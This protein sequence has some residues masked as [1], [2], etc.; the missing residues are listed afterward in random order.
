MLKIVKFT[1]ENLS[2]G[3]VT[4][5]SNPRFSFS[6][7]SDGQGGRLKRATLKINGET[8]DATEQIGIRYKGAPLKAFTKYTATLEAESD[9]GDRADASLEF[10]TGRMGNPWKAEW[11]TDGGYRFTEKKT[12]PVPMLFRKTFSF[13]KEIRSAKIYATAI[14]IYEL[15][16]NGKKVGRDY[17][18]PGFTSYKSRLQYQTYDVTEQIKKDNTL[19]AT[20]A[21]GWAVGA[22]VMSRKNRIT[23]P[24]QAFLAELRV[25]CADGT[26]AVLGTDE[27]WQVTREGPLR[28]AEFYDGEIFDATVSPE[29][30]S[31]T[32]ASAERLKIRP[33]LEA[34]YGAPVRAREAFRPV[35]VTRA[36]SGE[37][38]YDFGQNFAGVVKIRVKGKKGQKITVRHAEI[39]TS[40]GE[41]HTAYLRSAKC[42]LVYICRD[43]EQEYSPRMTY[44][45][46]RYAGV[47][48][49][50]EENIELSATALYSE[51][52]ETGVFECSDERI[53]RLQKNIVW[54]GKSN[55]V[56][57]PTD[58][59]QRD[60]RMGWTGDIA[61]FAPT[62]CYNFGMERFL[63]KWLKD[64]KSEQTK[65]GGIPNTVP[66][67]GYGFPETM[68][69][70]AVAFWGDACVFVPWAEY[71]AYGDKDILKEMYPVMKK[72]VKACLFWAGLFS[73]G[74]N[75]YIWNDIPAMQFGDWVAP[76]VPKM[77]EWQARCKWTGTAA[78]ARSTRLL[79]EIASILGNAEDAAKYRTISEKV[80]DAYCSI[81]TDGD[82]KL[83]EEF[84][85]AYVLP[86][87]FKMFPDSVRPKA[88]KN[89]VSLIEK[90]DYRIGTG[91]PGTPYILFALSDNGYA[92]VA[93][94]MLENTQC[95]SWLYE[96]EAGATTVWERW[97]GLDKD[98]T[99]PIGD[100]GTGGMISYN[101]YAFGAV[102]DFLYRRVAGIEATEGGYK[103]FRIAPLAGGGLT[104]ASGSVETPYGKITSAWRLADG[105]FH[106]EAEVPFGTECTLKM[107]SGAERVLESGRYAFS[108]SYGGG[109]K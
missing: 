77:L 40:E 24:R 55:F 30:I 23:A 54:S 27:T 74:K 7:S 22:F 67:Q 39:L 82:G 103:K 38:I 11:I 94:K 46:F 79:S 102:G 64:V 86:L 5:E 72:Y 2:E 73:F 20:V 104:F 92:D 26:E 69:K 99:C 42:R 31:W 19:T 62:A 97:D 101:H 75:K 71:M 58:C 14:G 6:L 34:S 16:L 63:N 25:V 8:I 57:I 68:P 41:L 29:K 45:G 35:S 37:L 47:T 70:K 98:G 106:I 81:L 17:F 96:V 95:P 48:G 105:E 4:D 3:C 80:S 56:D 93:Y 13:E 90:N 21:G 43:G 59:P 84:Q 109:A 10:E 78:L 32:N 52:P 100:D 88:A 18:A 85:T 51:I 9:N 65:G 36:K 66:S 91:F 15:E 60:E 83:K 12:S 1:C 108:E 89:L 50:S 87:Y 107:P 53:N 76:D 28:F 44:M 61:V 33:A 49:V